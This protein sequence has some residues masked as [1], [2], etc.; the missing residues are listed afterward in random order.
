MESPDDAEPEF[1]KP[2]EDD[3]PP[4]PVE[5][6]VPPV[7]LESVPLPKSLNL[8]EAYRTTV[9]FVEQYLSLED[10]PSED[11][12]LFYQY[13]LSDPAASEDFTDAI[14]RMNSWEPSL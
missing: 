10:S 5:P 9:F 6:Y 3:L 14:R 1:T 12:I 7:D 8:D 2:T 4:H 13:M 11:F